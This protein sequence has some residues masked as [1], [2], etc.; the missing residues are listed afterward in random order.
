MRSVATTR[1]PARSRPAVVHVED[2]RR[3]RRTFDRDIRVCVDGGGPKPDHAGDAAAA[4]GRRHRGDRRHRARARSVPSR[5][6]RSRCSRPSPTRRSSR[7]R[8]SACSRS[9]RRGTRE[10]TES[11]EQQTATAEI[12]AVIAARRPTSNRSSTRSSGARSSC[13]PAVYSLMFR[14]DGDRLHLAAT[15]NVPPEGL[16]ALR[17]RY[18]HSIRSEEADWPPGPC[19]S[20]A[21]ST[22]R[23]CRPCP[24]CQ[25]QR[26]W[27]RAPSVNG[28]R[29]R[30]P[31]CG[32]TTIIGALFVSR[33]EARAFFGDGRSTLLKT[34][35]DQAVIAIE[36]VR[37]FH[38]AARP[39]KPRS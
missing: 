33:R 18:P 31:C 12:L 23:T 22:S 6:S 28:P 4:R 34:F 7:S 25:W 16:E 35:A 37:L 1:G 9:C 11:L 2:I 8:T 29:W 32:R 39:R 21:C 14:F 20:D 26:A 3:R 30:C 17:R 38:G 27:R 10:L 15:H 36:N 24:T 13:V 19:G 5:T